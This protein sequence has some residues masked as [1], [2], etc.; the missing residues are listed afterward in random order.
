MTNSGIIVSIDRHGMNRLDNDP[1]SKAS[2][3]KTVDQLINSAVFG[4]KDTMRSISSQIMAGMVVKRRDW[5]V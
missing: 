4:E 5:N 2:F 1:L 3:E